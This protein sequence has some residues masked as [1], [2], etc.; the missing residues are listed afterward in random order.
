MRVRSWTHTHTHT[1][2]QSRAFWYAAVFIVATLFSGTLH[3]QLTVIGEDHCTGTAVIGEHHCTD[4]CDWWASLHA[5][6]WLVRTSQRFVE[7]YK[8]DS[9]TRH[10]MTQPQHNYTTTQNNTR[11]HTTTQHNHNTTTQPA[12]PK[13]TTVG[14]SLTSEKKKQPTIFWYTLRPF[15]PAFIAPYY[16]MLPCTTVLLSFCSP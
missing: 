5:L 14:T 4:Y 10:D 3:W 15:T 8:Q 16:T 7:T 6:L 12:Y 11:H 1:R 13:C 9:T 2:E